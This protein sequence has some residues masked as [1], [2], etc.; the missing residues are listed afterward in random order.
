M[1]CVSGFF[2]YGLLAGSICVMAQTARLVIDTSVNT[3]PVSPT[4]YGLMTEEINFSYDGGL[5]GDGAEP[6]LRCSMAA[7]RALGY[8]E[9]RERTGKDR[10]GRYRAE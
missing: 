10:R 5:Y 4:L 3:S 7:F 6:N 9:T 8:C 1:R 2:A